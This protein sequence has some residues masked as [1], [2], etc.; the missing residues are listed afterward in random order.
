VVSPARLSVMNAPRAAMNA[1]ATATLKAAPNN[2]TGRRR[3][4]PTSQ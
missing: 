3:H 4:K 2:S 1:T